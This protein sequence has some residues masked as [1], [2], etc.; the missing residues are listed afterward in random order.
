MENNLDNVKL[1]YSQEEKEYFPCP[2]CKRMLPV[3][4]AKNN[5]PYLTCNDC[6]L[7]LFI[8]GKE[9]IKRFKN[10]I[11]KNSNE[12]DLREIIN[13]ID[14]FDELIDRLKEIEAKKPMIGI[15]KD[16]HLQEKIIN[17]H[18]NKIRGILKNSTE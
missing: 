18:L 13:S 10:L 3:E 15:N 1:E 8:R 16:L 2:L 6:G 12:F 14:Y 4:N 9:G 5:K 7:K 11:G 17:I